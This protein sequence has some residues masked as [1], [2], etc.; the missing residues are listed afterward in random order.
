MAIRETASA[1]VHLRTMANVRVP[2][3]SHRY[4]YQGF[5]VLFCFLCF[6]LFASRYLLYGL[7]LRISFFVQ[8]TMARYLHFTE[9]HLLPRCTTGIVAGPS[10]YFFE[11]IAD[12]FEEQA[13]RIASSLRANE[14]LIVHSVP[15]ENTE[16]GDVVGVATTDGCEID[17]NEF[18]SRQAVRREFVANWEHDYCNCTQWNAYLMRVI[19]NGEPHDAER[20]SD[21]MI[22]SGSG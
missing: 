7:V 18:S 4:R 16:L 14:I 3:P 5:F 11:T 17:I 6:S 21:S 15:G 2:R 1:C 9:V 8:L 22:A 20:E 10:V 13:Y 19:D 12:N